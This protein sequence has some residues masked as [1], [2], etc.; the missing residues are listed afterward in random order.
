MRGEVGEYGRGVE[1]EWSVVRRKRKKS[2]L[3]NLCNLNCTVYVVF[4]P[5]EHRRLHQVF[6]ATHKDRA[7]YAG[8]KHSHLLS[9]NN[10]ELAVVSLVRKI[11]VNVQCILRYIMM[12]EN[13]AMG[14]R[15]MMLIF[16]PWQGDMWE[17]ERRITSQN[18][19]S[20]VRIIR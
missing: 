10:D 15:E 13:D 18:E 8:Q 2:Q 12:G 14:L 6:G 20:S 9:I 1:E 17:R 3:Q 7:R 11:L 19:K 16:V 4:C 5:T